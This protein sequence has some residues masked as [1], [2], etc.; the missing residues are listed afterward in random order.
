MALSSSSD[1]RILEW[2]SSIMVRNLII[3]LSN[4]FLLVWI[5]KPLMLHPV[6]NVGEYCPWVEKD[7][8][9]AS[10]VSFF[11]R[12]WCCGHL[13]RRNLLTRK[14]SGKC[15]FTIL[16]FF[17]CFSVRMVRCSTWTVFS[18]LHLNE[19]SKTLV[20]CAPVYWRSSIDP[21][22][23]RSY[24]E[25]YWTCTYW[26]KIKERLGN[27]KAVYAHLICGCKIGLWIIINSIAI[28]D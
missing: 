11:G 14:P 28:C 10:R 25:Y 22:E 18:N 4:P 20:E 13:R 8:I 17:V 6:R 24:R 1:I 2:E 3:K 26:H 21:A 16:L 9:L 19:P 23:W 5:C 12:I 27:I 7:G 15:H